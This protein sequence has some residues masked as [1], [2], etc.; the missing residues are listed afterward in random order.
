MMTNSEIVYLTN[1]N[2][3]D[4]FEYRT[5]YQMYYKINILVEYELVELD[6]QKIA[7]IFQTN[8]KH[9]LQIIFHLV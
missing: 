9:Y 2:W 7:Q 5:M 1:D 3:N 4:Y 8:L 6:K